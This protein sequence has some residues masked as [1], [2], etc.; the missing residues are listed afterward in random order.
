MHPIKILLPLAAILVTLVSGIVTDHDEVKVYFKEDYQSL[1][2]GTLKMTVQNILSDKNIFIRHI[3]I[4]K[5][6]PE[7]GNTVLFEVEEPGEIT[8]SANGEKLPNRDARKCIMHLSKAPEV[9]FV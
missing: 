5:S 7:L 6:H 4:D 8:H 2:E 9:M 3:K 1:S